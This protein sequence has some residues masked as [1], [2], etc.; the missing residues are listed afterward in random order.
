MKAGF[1]GARHAN[2]SRGGDAAALLVDGSTLVSYVEPDSLAAQASLMSLS[3]GS[4]V[5]P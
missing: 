1:E 4:E 2:R 3:G 5:P